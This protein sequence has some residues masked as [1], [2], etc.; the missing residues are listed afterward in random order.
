V[1]GLVSILDDGIETAIG[2][3]A[4][5]NVFASI[6]V[7]YKSSALQTDAVFK[8]LNVDPLRETWATLAACVIFVAIMARKYQWRFA[9]LNKKVQAP[10]T[11]EDGTVSSRDAIEI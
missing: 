8:Q 7:T 11:P 10:F 5:N 6:F 1:L 3:H 4:A 9:T 2:A